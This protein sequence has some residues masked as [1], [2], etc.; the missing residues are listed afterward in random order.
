[1]HLLLFISPDWL[2]FCH[3]NYVET[4]DHTIRIG[5][6]PTFK[7]FDLY[8]YSAYAAHYVYFIIVKCGPVI[9]F[10]FLI[11]NCADIYEHTSGTE[12]VCLAQ[13]LRTK[14]ADMILSLMTCSLNF[15]PAEMKIHQV[16][17]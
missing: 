4:L 3:V 6:T 10:Q 15:V 11:V 13:F 17:Y 8:L 12:V 14:H 9:F 2:T 16:Y 5:S 1:M 7:Y